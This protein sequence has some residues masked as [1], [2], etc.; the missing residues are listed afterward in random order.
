MKERISTLQSTIDLYYALMCPSWMLAKV[1]EAREELYKIKCDGYPACE[2]FGCAFEH[3][4][5]T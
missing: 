5:G 2:D 1:T 3:G 4:L